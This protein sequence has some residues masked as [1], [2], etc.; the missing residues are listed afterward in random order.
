[1]KS[2]WR[3]PTRPRYNGLR[4]LIR[5]LLGGPLVIVTG[6]VTTTL[7][8]SESTRL[9]ARQD[10]R[11]WLGQH[12][13]SQADLAE[14][15]GSSRPTVSKLLKGTVRPGLA[16]ALLI[17]RATS[18]VSQDD[19][20]LVENVPFGS[21]HSP[22]EQDKL[23]R[24]EGELLRVKDRQNALVRE[25]IPGSRRRCVERDVPTP[26]LSLAI[27]DTSATFVAVAGETYYVGIDGYQGA[28]GD[29]ELTLTCG[30][31]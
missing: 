31:L 18:Y 16:V 24:V 19:V 20:K 12:G 9:Y 29:A 2:G 11:A 21:W 3:W 8:L 28:A 25:A 13:V 15:I 7:E 27:G 1:M 23:D 4:S 6:L 5:T 17:E 26:A 10:L 22:E 30:S 14:R